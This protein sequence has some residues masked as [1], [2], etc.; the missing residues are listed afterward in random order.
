MVGETE[1]V[2]A[3]V[4]APSSQ[5]IGAF[6]LALGRLQAR[7]K[8]EGGSP[9]EGLTPSQ[10]AMLQ[11]LRDTGGLSVTQLAAAEHVSQQ[12]ITQR[13]A[14][15]APTG[16]VLVGRDAHDGRRKVVTITEAGEGLLDRVASAQ[17]TWLDRAV[18]QTLDDVDLETLAVAAHIMERLAGSDVA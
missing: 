8:Q 7:I 15:L 2:T 5:V 12:A 16:Y 9:A 14:L 18:S 1:C 10:L 3:S 17:E 13:L 11:R 4:H 6:G